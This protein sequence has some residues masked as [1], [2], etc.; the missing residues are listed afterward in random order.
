M[1]YFRATGWGQEGWPF[2]LNCNRPDFVRSIFT[3]DT[4]VKTNNK[5][6]TKGKLTATL[7]VSNM[8]TEDAGKS[9]VRFYL[10]DNLT[11]DASDV[12]LKTTKL[13][14]LKQGK[15]KTV[16]LKS[17]L[18]ESV[19]GK[20]LLAVLDAD[21]AVTESRETNNVSHSDQLP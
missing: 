8:G 11:L 16:K 10:S 13:G 2:K 14:K 12:E 1:P 7:M 19:T 6:K 15:S 17:K 5:G 3:A 21:C 9:V 20:I 4:R 18:T